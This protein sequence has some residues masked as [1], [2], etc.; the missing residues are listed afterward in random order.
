M[1][2]IK[3]IIKAL[4][5]EIK[6]AMLDRNIKRAWARMAVDEEELDRVKRLS[7]K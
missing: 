5:H 1:W 3:M 6:S 2:K 4:R 7:Q